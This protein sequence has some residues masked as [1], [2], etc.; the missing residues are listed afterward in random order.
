MANW[1]EINMKRKCI[2]MRILLAAVVLGSAIYGHA[3]DRV[4]SPSLGF[5][6]AHSYALADIESIDKATGSLALHIPLAQLPPGPAGFTAGLTLVYN[7]KYWEIE[8]W[9]GL[10]EMKE[11]FSG[12]WR[13]SMLPSLDVEYVLSKGELDP[14]GYYP[15]SELF[16]MRLTDPDGGRSTLLLSKPVRQMPSLCEAGIYRMSQLKNE[17]A[18]S[19]WYTTDGTYLRLE[20]DA[21]SVAGIW[22]HNSSWTLYRQDGSSIR[23]EVASKTSY[24]KDR[25]GNKI[26]VTKTADS[27]TPSHTYEIMKDEFGRTIRLDHF[28]FDRDEVSQTGHDG[29]LL[30]WKVYYG[31]AGSI[32]PNSYIC[33]RS[34]ILNCAFESLPR[35]ATRLE[36]PNGLSYIFGYERPAPFASNYRELRTL[37]LP[38][39]AKVEYG[40]KLDDKPNPTNYYHILA[41]PITSKTIFLNGAAIQKWEIGYDMNMSTGAYARNTHKAPDGAVTSYEFRLV[42]YG[43]GLDPDS[44]TITKIVNPDGSIINRD[45]QSNYPRE[46]PS[47]LFWANPWIRREWTTSANS[48]GSPVATSVR[49]FTIDKNGNTTSVEERGWLP[50]SSTLGDP[51]SAPLLRKTVNVYLNGATD[52]TNLTSADARAYSYASLASPSV[53]RNLPISIEIRDGGG[54]VKS[55]SQFQYA[56]INPARIVGNL[57]AEYRWDSTKPGYASI[58]SGTPLT[59]GNAVVKRYEYTARGNLKKEIDARGIPATYDYGYIPGC[60]AS[61][62]TDLYRTGAH[63]GQNGSAALLD[64][65]YSYNCNSGKRI[66]TTDP[67]SLVTS[68]SHDRYGRPAV[69]LEGNYR[70]T[71]HTYDDASLWVVT[72]KD[73]KSFNDLRNVTVNHY[74]QLGRL[75]LSRQLETAVSS[76]STA[77]ANESTGIRTDTRYVYSLNRNETWVSNPYRSTEAGAPTRG[78]TVRRVD[79]AG[80][81]CIEEWFAGALNPAVAENCAPSPGSTGSVIHKYNASQKWTSVETL[82]AAGKTRRMYYDVLGRLIAVREDPASA[83]YDTYYQYDLLDNLVGTRQAGSCGASDPVATPCGGGQT[84]SFT[85]DSLKR[86]S[87]VLNPEMGGNAVSYQYDENGNVTGRLSSGSPSLLVSYAYDSLNR[88]RTRDYSDG[89][90]PPVTYCYDGTV[91][92]RRFGGCSGSVSIPSKGRLTNVS[93]SVSQ[94][95][96]V[97]DT[98]GRIT[99]SIQTTDGDS[100][101]FEYAYNAASALI[102]ETYPSG[103]RIMSEYDDAGRV[104]FLSGQYASVPANYAGTSGNPI[105]YASHGAISSMTL[106]NGVVESRSY[107]SRLQ[108]T[109]IQA[110]GLLTIW[111]CYQ[112]GDDAGCS[113]L[114][115]VSANNGNLQGQKIKRGAQSW[116]QKYTYDGVNRLGS[117]QET[118]NWQQNYGYDPYGNRWIASSSGLPVSALTPAGQNAFAAATNRL[119]GTDNYDSRGNLKSYG[120]YQ[121]AYEG[122]G[123]VSSASGVLP[124][125]RFEYDGEGRRVRTYSCADMA[126]CNL[127]SGAS[128]TVYVYDAFGRLAAEYSPNPAQSGTSYLTLD[129]LGS[130]RLETNASGQQIKCSDYLPFGE[131]IPAGYGSR[132]SCFGDTDNRI[133][134]TGKERDAETGL[135]NFGARYFS[136][137]QGRFTSPDPSSGGIAIADPQSWNL[138]SYVRNRPTRYVD[139]NGNWATEIHEQIVRFALKDY[140]SAGDLKKLI[141]QQSIMDKRYNAPADQYMH[142]MSNGAAGE[143]AEA[144]TKKMDKFLSWNLDEA[145]KNLREDGSFS[146]LSLVRFGSALH[147]IQDWTCPM[148]T[149]NGV[150]L[151]WYGMLHKSAPTHYF[152]E[153]EPSDD[154]AAIGKAVR[155]T[156]MF[157]MA[158]NPQ[159]MAEAGLAWANINREAEKQITR[160]VEWWSYA[161]P[162]Q[163]SQA[164]KEADRQC[165]LGNPAACN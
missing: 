25:N 44:G 37:T 151:P 72:Q 158:V 110:G 2:A 38:T 41:N 99:K 91:W 15:Y 14:C 137:F 98:A 116:T 42:S 28:G 63:Q 112:A 155:L 69:I 97:Y 103:R 9:D 8:P 138:Y 114:A 12:G 139:I 132:S 135:D 70:K 165:A 68:V 30:V 27:H 49:V 24:L 4:I 133:R 147:T 121:L 10:F 149:K 61:A 108:P 58:S 53:P 130:L 31:S 120:P 104:K 76:P 71:V 148:H 163:R 19:V 60:P 127:R 143:S 43:L 118:N 124:S 52:S 145:N 56:E 87:T 94:T 18:P 144:A 3:E 164:Q 152:G 7:N 55:R 100:F 16:R 36:L 34:L 79:K 59:A 154:W 140:L 20:I 29:T 146:D 117:A 125:A 74:D 129:H 105:K 141:N 84:R 1:K 86:L 11:S 75:R 73:A 39:G 66:S 90:T 96:Y 82:D 54:A 159:G 113:S 136:A 40:Y 126:V 92:N 157:A 150:P 153:N 80:R 88:V 17:N 128:T 13:L 22:P 123:R 109:K 51:A 101:I 77:A 46:R 102:S 162:G 48:S 26:A 134:F 45:W 161:N 85:Y 62:S 64:W 47:G 67:N 23:Y 95:S 65:S 83:R 131:E 93:S 50:Y 5:Q 81:V 122:D 111:N 32:I 160:Y 21:P 33:D 6:P 57:T 142:A 115:A 107:N 156:M 78:W 89:T 35:M 119:V 106:G